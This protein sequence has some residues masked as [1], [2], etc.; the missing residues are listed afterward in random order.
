MAPTDALKVAV[1]LGIGLA[2]MA[3]LT[4]K[5]TTG[6]SFSTDKVNSGN[7]LTVNQKKKKSEGKK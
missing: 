4:I 2:S 7:P 5:L 3:Y 1:P 6:Y